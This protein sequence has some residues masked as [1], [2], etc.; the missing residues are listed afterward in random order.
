MKLEQSEAQ[1]QKAYV[2]L[3]WAG[4]TDTGQKTQ[5]IP[6]RL[7]FLLEI[8]PGDTLINR[9]GTQRL[10]YRTIATRLLT[11]TQSQS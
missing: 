3:T 5:N 9:R 10:N 1:N 11:E 2:R 7:V 8:Q 4:A 6:T